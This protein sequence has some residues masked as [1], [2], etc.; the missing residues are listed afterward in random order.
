MRGKGYRRGW[1]GKKN[2]GLLEENRGRKGAVIIAR[3]GKNPSYFIIVSVGNENDTVW[4][5]RHQ[6]LVVEVSLI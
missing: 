2:D 4:H 1:Y 3:R 6:G 5:F